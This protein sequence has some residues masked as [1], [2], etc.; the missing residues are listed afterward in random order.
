MVA[1]P[2]LITLAGLTW[3]VLL[4]R[5]HAMGYGNS[6]VYVERMGIAVM[7]IFAVWAFYFAL[8]VGMP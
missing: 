4:P 5:E 3:A 6:F 2:I 8:S 7:F 1:I